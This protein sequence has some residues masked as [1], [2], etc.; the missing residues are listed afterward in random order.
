MYT[1]YN[2]LHYVLLTLS[3]PLPYLSCFFFFSFKASHCIQLVCLYVPGCRMIQQNMATN[4]WLCHQQNKTKMKQ[5]QNKK[6][7]TPYTFFT[8]YELSV[9]PQPI[10]GSPHYSGHLPIHVGILM[11]FMW[12]IADII[13]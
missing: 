5:K 9:G 1:M 7:K 6:R 13:S 8:F 11:E 2:F 4:L 3:C 12:F 10:M